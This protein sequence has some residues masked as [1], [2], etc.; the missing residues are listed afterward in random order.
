MLL[1]QITSGL[2]LSIHYSC[3][4]DSANTSVEYII[5]N[6]EFGWFLKFAHSSGA[7]LIFLFLY[8]HIGK[9]LYFRSFRKKLVWYSG[10]LIFFLMMGVSFLGYTL[11]YGQ[12]SLWGATVITNLIGVIFPPTYIDFV[13][14]AWGGNSVGEPT[15]KRFYTFH[16]IL[17]FIILCLMFLHIYLLHLKGSSNPIGV[18]NS[19]DIVRFYPRYITKDFFGFII[20]GCFCIYFLT[21]K[22]PFFINDP[23]NYIEANPLSTPKHITPEWYFLPFYGMLRS[24]PDKVKGVYVMFLSILILFFIPLIRFRNKSSSLCKIFQFLFW[25][26]INNFIFLGWLAAHPIVTPF[27]ELS[28]IST[29]FYFAYILLLLPLIAYLEKDTYTYWHLGHAKI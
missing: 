8:I 9:G 16:F 7:S 25:C 28:Q 24:I 13:S 12:M 26:F 11:P 29:I 2:L 6:I 27:I 10:L 20:I 21:L 4:A 3:T 14:F 18:T 22:N 1:L 19:I 23:D 5:R 15:I 17:P